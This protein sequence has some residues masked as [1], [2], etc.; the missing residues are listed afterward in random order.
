MSRLEISKTAVVT[1]VVVFDELDRK[2]CE[3]VETVGRHED[4]LL[5]EVPEIDQVPLPEFG[6]ISEVA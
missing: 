6:L 5:Q 2:F 1:F 3:V 4:L